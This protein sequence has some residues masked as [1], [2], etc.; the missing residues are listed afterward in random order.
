MTNPSESIP[1]SPFPAA[2]TPVPRS[3]GAVARVFA[4]VGAVIVLLVGT[5]FSVGAALAAPVGMAVAAWL[6]RRRG[7]R[8][9]AIGHWAAAMCGVVVAVVFYAGLVS[10]FVPS[11]TWK[12]IQ[13]AADSAQTASA[14]TP[15]PA[16]LDRI[17]PGMAQQEAARQANV[18][19]RTK[20]MAMAFGLGITAVMFGLFFGSIGWVAGML[21]G[22]SVNGRWPGAV[23]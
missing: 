21:L 18:S 22:L 1:A 5:V 9:P 20:S 16:W 14:R 12:Q 23:G 17:A 19:D 2:A 3:A 10:A 15:P 11:A 7:K 8:L 13:H 6:W 4:F